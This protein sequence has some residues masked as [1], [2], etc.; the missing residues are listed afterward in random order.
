MS[1][2][3]KYFSLTLILFFCSLSSN[4]ADKRSNETEFSYYEDKSGQQ[5]IDEI[6][7]ISDHLWQVKKKANYGYSQSSIWVRFNL[8]KISNLNEHWLI[9]INDPRM[10]HISI[11]YPTGKIE[12]FG[13]SVPIS[14]R[15]FY[16]R[17]PVTQISPIILNQY[18]YLKLKSF[19]PIQPNISINTESHFYQN[20]AV[21]NTLFGAYFGIMLVMLLYNFFIYLI[22]KIQSY[23]YYVIFLATTIFVNFSLNGFTHLWLFPEN[24]QLNSRLS[25]LSFLAISG[26]SAIV[27]CQNF[28]GITKRHKGIYYIFRAYIMLSLSLI[29]FSLTLS[30][31][32]FIHIYSFFVVS[33]F[34][35]VLLYASIYGVI[36]RLN[37]AYYFLIAWMFFLA[38][39]VV[40]IMMASGALDN[41]YFTYYSAQAGSLVEVVLLSIALAAR[42]KKLQ[43]EKRWTTIR[44]NQQLL[45]LNQKLTKSNQLKDEFLTNIS[46]E[47]R[48]PI[49][50]AKGAL[51]LLEKKKENNDNFNLAKNSINHIQNIIEKLLLLTEGK[52]NHLK[53]EERWFTFQSILKKLETNYSIKNISSLNINDSHLK[54]HQ[55]FGQ[56]EP[57]EL[58]ITELVDNALKFSDNKSVELCIDLKDR[59]PRQDIIVSVIDQGI[60]IN[61][62][63][64]LF[65]PFWQKQSNNKRQYEGLGIGLSVIKLLCDQLSAK[66]KLS[67]NDPSGTK[68]EFI[69]NLE[70]REKKPKLN[71]LASLNNTKVLI[72]EDNLVNKTVINAMVKKLGCQSV[73]AE[74]GLQALELLKNQS[75]DII[76]MD[77]QMPIMDGFEATKTIRQSKESFSNVPI[78][79]VTANTTAKDRDRC[80]EVG[81]NAFL[82]KPIEINSLERLMSDYI[83]KSS[84]DPQ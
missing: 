6:Q 41:N 56:L 3:L 60:G 7:L 62:Q 34:P 1:E 77:C 40:R 84:T 37:Q 22:V 39:L 70:F 30:N 4:A 10:D 20:T 45:E 68:A 71:H 75:V 13:E 25:I 11:Y 72:V 64:N 74:N 33:L 53:F 49:N 76:L 57:I 42:I 18:Y 19:D 32:R 65:E 59:G 69:I 26:I 46:H 15:T 5:S 82:K 73:C 29:I 80:F 21:E 52:N 9:Q 12:N 81:M 47:L 27:F 58:I 63:Q 31:E 17:Y 14:Q 79:A 78:I 36:K 54:T 51:S 43:Q 61:N 35:L 55:Y 66:I 8:N 28:L 67:K 38:G 48:T 23:K 44:T 50:G 16:Y 24:Y 83:I 2:K